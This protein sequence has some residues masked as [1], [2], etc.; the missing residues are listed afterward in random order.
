MLT[1][2]NLLSPRPSRPASSTHA[3]IP[4]LQPAQHLTQTDQLWPAHLFAA[5]D[6]DKWAPLVSFPLSSPVF[7]PHRVGA[8]AVWPRVATRGLTARDSRRQHLPRLPR[9]RLLSL[10]ATECSARALPPASCPSPDAKVP[11]PRPRPALPFPLALTTSAT[12]CP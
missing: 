11:Q 10:S 4:G 6:T 8:D 1:N 5:R 9:C 2:L 7:L 3:T 12:P